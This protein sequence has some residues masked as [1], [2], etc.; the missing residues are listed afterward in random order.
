MRTFAFY[1]AMLCGAVTAGCPPP[2]PASMAPCPSDRTV[3][4]P[5]DTARGVRPAH[6][7]HLSSAPTASIAMMRILV[8]PEGNAL[9]DSTKILAMVPSNSERSTREAAEQAEYTPATLN[10]CP[11]SFWLEFG[12]FVASNH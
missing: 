6:L 3:Y 9:P 10:G 4:T 12:Y 7:K 5:A 8:T 1:S 2:S 11:V